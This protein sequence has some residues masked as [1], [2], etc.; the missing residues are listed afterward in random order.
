VSGSI[1]PPNH[2][3]FETTTTTGLAASTGL[4]SRWGKTAFPD[5]KIRAGVALAILVPQLL[6]AL[7]LPGPAGVERAAKRK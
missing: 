2:P 7:E 3:S 5:E 6:V 1:H 4:Y